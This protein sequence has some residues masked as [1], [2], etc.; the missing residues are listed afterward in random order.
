MF[1]GYIDLV[2]VGVTV[3]DK[4]RQLI[5]T[6]DASDF[7]VYEDGKLQTIFAFTRGEHTGPPLHVGVLLDVSGSQAADLRFTQ[8]A[9]TRFLTLLADAV[10]MTF[11]DFADNV[12][13][14]RFPRSDLP[15]LAEHVRQLRAGGGTAL[16][17]VIGVYLEGAA[18]QD[19]RKVMGLY[20]R[21]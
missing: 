11:I 6:L 2:N 14:A 17:A 13:A 1:R 20:R 12:H 9:V 3:A 18:A 15:L 8:T 5:T 16:Y 10:D 21:R 7:A 4:K 19:G